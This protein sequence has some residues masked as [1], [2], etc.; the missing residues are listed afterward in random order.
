MATGISALLNR[1]ARITLALSPWALSLY[2]QY[3]L[4][5]AGI[6]TVDMPFRA[7]LSA[8]IIA[9]GMLLSFWV[10]TRFVASRRP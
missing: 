9:T 4:E 5:Y 8:A 7:L 2:L 10:Y 6:W 3:W 1:F